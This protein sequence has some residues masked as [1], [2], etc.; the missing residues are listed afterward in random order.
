MLH[1]TWFELKI[2]DFKLN[3]AYKNHTP[4]SAHPKSKEALKN[5][6]TS[7]SAIDMHYHPNYGDYLLT[8]LQKYSVFYYEMLLIDSAWDSII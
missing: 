6:L 5:F 4:V 8:L 1:Y 7:T 3:T 2:C